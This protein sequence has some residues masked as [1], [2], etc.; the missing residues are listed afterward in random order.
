MEIVIP[1][2]LSTLTMVKRKLQQWI[3]T[4]YVPQQWIQ[5]PY[6]YLLVA[7]VGFSL[8]YIVALWFFPS[9]SE[10]QAWLSRF[11][12]TTIGSYITVVL[13]DSSFRE[14][15]RR[16]RDRMR[17]IALS[18]VL[19]Q[20]NAHLRLV[21]DM[22]ISSIPDI[23]SEI[24]DSYEELFDAD[25]RN[26]L[27]LLDFSKQYPTVNRDITY[28]QYV[29][30]SLVKSREEVN[31]IIR[32]YGFVM[33]PELVQ[34]L[35]D[36]NNSDL[37]SI[38]SQSKKVDLFSLPYGPS[39]ALLAA[40]GPDDMIGDYL[41]NLLTLMEYFKDSELSEPVSIED[42][43]MWREDTTPHAGRAILDEVDI[44]RYREY[45]SNPPGERDPTQLVVS[46]GKSETDQEGQE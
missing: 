6:V 13:V 15:E 24:P 12:V 40:E 7:G 10:A 21:S 35:K 34:N 28:L 25:L 29:G 31:D 18:E 16:E 1:C 3:Q 14:Q 42:L 38:L 44:E 37:V 19:E 36:L 43:S 32:R 33:E 20:V 11:A 23:P 27:K 45:L 46:D 5:T 41:S 26:A 22:Y 4:P 8:A 30:S 39:G 2:L 9:R 17:E